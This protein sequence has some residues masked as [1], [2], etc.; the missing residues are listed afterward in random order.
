MDPDYFTTQIQSHY[1]AEKCH[2]NYIKDKPW[3]LLFAVILSAQC[4][5]KRVNATTPLLF[6][7][8]PDLEHFAA[9]PTEELEMIIKPLGFYKNKSKSLKKCAEQL[10]LNFNGKLPDTMEDLTTLAG[11][12]RKTANVILWNIFEK[13]VGFVVDT[14]I[15]RITQRVGLTKQKTPVKIEQDLMKK[16]PQDKW[17]I[18]SH[19]LIQFGRE[20]CK[21]PTPVC[22]ECFMREKCLKVGVKKMK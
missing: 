1:K 16:L 3:T 13:N 14:H 4:T 8:F 21:A 2:L 15:G 17:G 9:K 20:I 22:S 18:L 19:E 6:A 10:L 12:G 7:K 11:V 5:D